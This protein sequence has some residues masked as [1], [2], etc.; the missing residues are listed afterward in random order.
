VQLWLQGK[1][2][3]YYV[4]KDCVCNRSNPACN[5][6]APVC[7]LWPVQLYRIFPL[8]LINVKINKKK[9]LNTKCVSR[10]SLWLL[11]E[12]FLILRRTEQDIK[13]VCWSSCAV[14][15]SSDFSETPIF[16]TDFLKILKY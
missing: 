9:F 5:A 14:P 13:N 6:Q 3:K 1:S 15:L 4:S 8:Y 12:T 11:C 16:L 7:N 2:N 10:I